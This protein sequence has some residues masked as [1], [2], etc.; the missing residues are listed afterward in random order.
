MRK[1]SIVIKVF[2]TH[3]Y[4]TSFYNKIRVIFFTFTFYCGFDTLGRF[5]VKILLPTVWK[6]NKWRVANADRVIPGRS[7][8]PYKFINQAIIL[9][10]VCT[11][12]DQ[13]N[14]CRVFEQPCR[15]VFLSSI[16]CREKMKMHEVC[17]CFNCFI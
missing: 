2:S 17:I 6:E 16:I 5:K 3:W 7:I 9:N 14:G 13:K 12:K 4:I 1:K 8:I 11:L 15:F 10:G